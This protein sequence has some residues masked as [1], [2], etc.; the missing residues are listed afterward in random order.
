MLAMQSVWLLPVLALALTGRWILNHPL[1]LQNFRPLQIY[2]E[3]I[4]ALAPGLYWH[5]YF[6][7]FIALV[8]CL[9]GLGIILATLTGND[10]FNLLDGLR[11]CGLALLLLLTLD[12]FK[13]LLSWT[14]PALATLSL[15]L[16]LAISPV[17]QEWL[18]FTWFDRL[19]DLAVIAYLF[20]F[21]GWVMIDQGC[22][23]LFAPKI[24]VLPQNA[25]P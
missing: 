23:N 24:L 14:R 15:L 16:G 21:A 19:H 2:E 10:V 1:S 8:Y 5:I 17:N 13:R 22:R 11:D 3:K 12:F 25:K 20:G 7:N 18:A 9:Q 6:L 4:L